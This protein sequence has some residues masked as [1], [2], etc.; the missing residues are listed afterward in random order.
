MAIKKLGWIGLA[1]VNCLALLSIDMDMLGQE[2]DL[3]RII[4]REKQKEVLKS[5]SYNLKP[6]ELLLWVR[7][8]DKI[9]VVIHG[10][11]L[12]TVDFPAFFPTDFFR[13]VDNLLNSR[14]GKQIDDFTTIYLFFRTGDDTA[15]N[16]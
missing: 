12:G 11:V 10:E 4:L 6:G 2:A 3:S 8:D 1:F 7:T 15:K 5:I 14:V 9:W 13:S 16:T